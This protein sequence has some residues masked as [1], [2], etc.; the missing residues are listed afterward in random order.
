MP[1]ESG[2]YFVKRRDYRPE[3]IKQ[4][5]PW[6]RNWEPAEYV[7]GGSWLLTGTSRPFSDDDVEVGPRISYADIDEG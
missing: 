2:Y 1:R 5:F 3:K 6:T 4:Q 7:E